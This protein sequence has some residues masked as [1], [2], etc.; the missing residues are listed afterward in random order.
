MA[1]YLTFHTLACLTRQGAAQLVERFRQAP[2]VRLHRTLVNLQDGKMLV[3]WEAPERDALVRWL[4]AEKM[5]RDW[6]LRVEYEAR[7]GPLEPAT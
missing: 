7:D 3:E 1:R 6:L 5:H 4:D 2:G